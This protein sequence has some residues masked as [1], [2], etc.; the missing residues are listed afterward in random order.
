MKSHS[1]LKANCMRSNQIK[2]RLIFTMVTAI[3]AIQGLIAQSAGTITTRIGNLSFENGSPTQETSKKL[4]DE[5]DFQRAVQAYLWAYPAV[6]F[7]SIRLAAKNDLG[8]DLNEFGIADN[9]VD[10]RS[11]WLTANNTTIY[12]FANI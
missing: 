11:V 3:I 6:S 4:F 8:I 12:A 10:P 9:F 2:R 1:D 5:M 7:E